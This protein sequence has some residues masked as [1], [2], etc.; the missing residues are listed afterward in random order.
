MFF[1]LDIFSK[2]SANKSKQAKKDRIDEKKRGRKVWEYDGSIGL[3]SG[4]GI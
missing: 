1:T 3:V 4:C 2:L